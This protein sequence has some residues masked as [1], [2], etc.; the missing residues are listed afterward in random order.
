ME[1]NQE[2]VKFRNENFAT[3]CD[4]LQHDVFEYWQSR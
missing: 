4:W 2:R 1:S 3:V